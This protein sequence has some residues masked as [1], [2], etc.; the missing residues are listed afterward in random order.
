MAVCLYDVETSRQAGV[1]TAKGAYIFLGGVIFG[2][3]DG[4]SSAEPVSRADQV[5]ALSALRFAVELRG[6]QS[7]PPG[8]IEVLDEL[9]YDPDLGLEPDQEW[10]LFDT[11]PWPDDID[12][13]STARGWKA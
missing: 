9:D 13:R 3:A 2:G 10:D 1:T 8:V 11:C 6:A 5:K 7:I 12:Q 4:A